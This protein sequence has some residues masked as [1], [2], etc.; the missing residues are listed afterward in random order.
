MAKAD[1]EDQLRELEQI[2]EWFASE[3]VDIDQAV[4]KYEKG[5]KIVNN[6][7][8]RLKDAEIKIN[9]IKEIYPLDKDQ[10]DD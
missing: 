9:E 3:D 2:V 1:F 7:Q 6:L 10:S 4:D 5:M 8:S